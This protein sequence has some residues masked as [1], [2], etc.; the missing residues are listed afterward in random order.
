MKNEQ[1]NQPYVKVFDKYGNVTNPIQGVL[2]PE[3]PNRR[4][5][6][7]KH[8]EPKGLIVY[9]KGGGKDLSRTQIILTYEKTQTTTTPDKVFQKELTLKKIRGYWN[10]KVEPMLKKDGS[11]ICTRK[12]KPRYQIYKLVDIKA[13]HHSMPADVYARQK[14]AAERSR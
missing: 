9:N 10:Y 11:P 12:G 14:V 2:R 7:Y 1:G 3:G 8:K 6:R 4:Q 5:R 13:V